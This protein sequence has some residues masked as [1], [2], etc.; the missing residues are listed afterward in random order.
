MPTFSEQRHP[1]KQWAGKAHLWSGRRA[2]LGGHR[3][4]HQ[5]LGGLGGLGCA[6]LGSEGAA[7]NGAGRDHPIVGDHGVE[8]WGV[9]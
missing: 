1:S 9:A 6:A 5:S 3:G 8:A 2:D 4:G 7:G